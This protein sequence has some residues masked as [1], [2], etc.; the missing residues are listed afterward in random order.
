MSKNS[1]IFFIIWINNLYQLCQISEWLFLYLMMCHALVKYLLYIQLVH[2]DNLVFLKCLITV[3]V[4]IITCLKKKSWRA[5][6]GSL[7]PFNIF[8]LLTRHSQFK[9]WNYEFLLGK[10]ITISLSDQICTNG[11][12]EYNQ[13]L[14]DQKLV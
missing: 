13:T 12:R 14:L 5:I 3:F 8:L 10:N 2:Q 9:L 11:R 4:F 7:F 1:S 6:S